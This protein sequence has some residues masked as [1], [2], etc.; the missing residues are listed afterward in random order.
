MDATSLYVLPT[1]EELVKEFVG[2]SIKDVAT[3]AAVLDLGKV[4]NNCSRMLE[5]C[6][7]LEFGWRAHIKTH[8]VGRY[9]SYDST[10]PNHK[11]SLSSK[12]AILL[13][14]RARFILKRPLI[15]PQTQL[16]FCK[17][18]ELT[19]LQVGSGTGPVNIIVSTLVEAEF[20]LPLL[21]EYKS[22]GRA[23][24]VCPIPAIAPPV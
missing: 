20:V 17:T 3:P 8:K 10:F 13:Y 2:K 18:I 16:T 9:R 23:V 1:K 15:S 22:Q 11:T 4:K 5:A 19:R 12:L 14:F 6:S 24:N 7:T 21:L